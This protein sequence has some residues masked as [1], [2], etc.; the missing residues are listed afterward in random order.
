MS[1]NEEPRGLPPIPPLDV[2]RLLRVAAVYKEM[3]FQVRALDTG[4]RHGEPDININAT[5]GALTLAYFQTEANEIALAAR[6]DARP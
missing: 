1:R 3:R 2:A 6:E 5:A 4:V